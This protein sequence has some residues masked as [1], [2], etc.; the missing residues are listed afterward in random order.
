MK[1]RGHDL[2]GVH[3]PEREQVAD[4]IGQT[5]DRRLPVEGQGHPQRVVGIPQRELAVVNLGPG[6]A[7]PGDHFIDLVP[8]KSVVH[9]DP[10]LLEHPVS[11]KASRIRR[12]RGRV[13]RPGS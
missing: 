1:Q 11:R 7:R 4:E 12:A 8:G 13:A 5:E 2:D 9:Q 6:Q 3:E 10:V